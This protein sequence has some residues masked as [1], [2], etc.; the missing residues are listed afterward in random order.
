MK[1]F[2]AILAAAVLSVAIPIA[3]DAAQHQAI[4]VKANI[5][6]KGER[7]ADWMRR[8]VQSRLRDT[9]GPPVIEWRMT[10][11]NLP[12]ATLIPADFDE[13]RLTEGRVTGNGKTRII[14]FN[15]YKNGNFIKKLRVVCKLELLAD[16]V[17]AKT[18][19]R[20]GSVVTREM[21]DIVR[22]EIT[23]PADDF[24]TEIAQVTGQQA[25][26]TIRARRFLRKSALEAVPAI[27]SGEIVM[28]VADN[29]NIKITARGIA[30]SDG[31]MGEMIPVLSLRSNKKI[32][33]RVIG[34]GTVRVSF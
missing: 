5:A 11:I 28:I 31:A 4:L 27:R 26:R 22:R 19:V 9:I 12:P 24:C 13:Y 7:T 1:I 29:G 14:V 15:F 6:A 8:A 10:A 33:A 32:H 3:A 34:D 23:L 16:I 25:K 20:R 21:L 2:S 17:V 18:T 30:K